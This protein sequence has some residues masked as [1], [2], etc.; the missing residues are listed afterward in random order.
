MPRGR[1]FPPGV[2]GNPKG[3][4]SKPHRLTLAMREIANENG[5]AIFKRIA[6]EAKSGDVN[7]MRLFLHFLAP[8]SRLIDQP[9]KRPP[10]ASVAEAVERI[11]DTVV[12]VEAGRLSFEEAEA[13]IGGARAFV[14][15]HR[16]AELETEVE[17]LRGQVAQLTSLVE[18]QMGGGK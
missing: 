15:A 9:V 12:G 2:S 6:N 18:R 7:A 8:R 17:A 10:I 11:A 14:E 1:P 3:A 16:T 4:P 13:L 5:R